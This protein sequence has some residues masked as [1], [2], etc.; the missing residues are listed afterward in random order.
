LALLK[1]SLSAQVVLAALQ[2]PQTTITEM[3]EL[4]D[5]IHR[6]GLGRLLAVA[7]MVMAAQQLLEQEALV[8]VV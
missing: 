4:M 6:L 2:K 3:E 8:A 1:Q 7:A 5:Q